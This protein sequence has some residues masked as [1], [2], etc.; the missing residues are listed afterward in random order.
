MLFI[1]GTQQEA[2]NGVIID[3]YRHSAGQQIFCIYQINNAGYI[4]VVPSKKDDM[5]SITKSIMVACTSRMIIL[6][7]PHYLSLC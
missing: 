4:I 2:K 7:H 6:F 1:L 3:A 5:T